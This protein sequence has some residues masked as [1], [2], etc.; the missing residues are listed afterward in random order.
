ML[1]AVA[2]Y[3]ETEDE[4]NKLGLQLGLDT[5]T[6]E[7]HLDHTQSL[8]ENAHTALVFWTQTFPTENQE[9]VLKSALQEC[10]LSSISQK[11]WQF[12]GKDARNV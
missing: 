7:K 12:T 9:R 4:L 6:I 5:D 2:K 8:S 1:Q 10:G 3:I 11:V